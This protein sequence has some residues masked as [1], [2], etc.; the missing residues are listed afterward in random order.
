[1]RGGGVSPYPW[2]APDPV[3]AVT[4]LQGAK[5]AAKFED[6]EA[7]LAALL[8]P[9]LTALGTGPKLLSAQIRAMAEHKYT[10][11]RYMYKEY[12]KL[13]DKVAQDE[14]ALKEELKV[15]RGPTPW[16]LGRPPHTHKHT[17]RDAP[18]CRVCMA[19]AWT[20]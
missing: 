1:M 8:G 18:H 2:A 19:L 6:P 9:T 4:L 20:S 16:N 11:D 13:A 12:M 15:G 17:H 5:A 7:A 14:A 3:N 10:P